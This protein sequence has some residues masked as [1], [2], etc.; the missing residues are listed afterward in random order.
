MKTGIFL[1]V[2]FPLRF[3]AS[4]SQREGRAEGGRG[5]GGVGWAEGFVHVMPSLDNERTLLGN[6][7]EDTA[8]CRYAPRGDTKW[9]PS[10]DAG[11]PRELHK[12]VQR[13]PIDP[14]GKVSV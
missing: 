3:L 7:S 4:R 5:M 14:H 6:Q 11:P 2:L 13:V 12:V 8:A 9:C 1:Q 10:S